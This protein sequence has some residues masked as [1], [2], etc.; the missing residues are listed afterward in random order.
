MPP[1]HRSPEQDD[2]EEER[3]LTVPSASSSGIVPSFACPSLHH[4]THQITP[5]HWSPE[6][7]VELVN[8]PEPPFCCILVEKCEPLPHDW[9][10]RDGL[11]VRNGKLPVA[12]NRMQRNSESLV[13]KKKKK[14]KKKKLGRKQKARKRNETGLKEASIMR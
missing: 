4:T 14:K 12:R 2:F 7:C 1:P 3:V 10:S 8:I 6:L 5:P 9:K 11:L 13:Q